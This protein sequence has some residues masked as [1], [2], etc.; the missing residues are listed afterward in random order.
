MADAFILVQ[1]VVGKAGHVAGAI[2]AL[3]D[4]TTAEE[5]LGPYDVVVRATSASDADLAATI[6]QIQQVAGI[7]RTVTCHVPA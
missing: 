5:V 4:V 7:T 6:A 3:G 2:A 1:T